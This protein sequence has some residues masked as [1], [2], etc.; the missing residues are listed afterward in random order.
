LS[1]HSFP[2]EFLNHVEPDF[3]SN[4]SLLPKMDFAHAESRVP[5]PSLLL[6]IFLPGSGAVFSIQ[7]FV[8][9]FRP[10]DEMPPL[11]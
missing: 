7:S 5:L 3:Q 11:A 4:D 2:Q 1:P 9:D 8:D 10:A 6:G